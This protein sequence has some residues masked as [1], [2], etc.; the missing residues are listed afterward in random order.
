[1]EREVTDNCETILRQY[2][3][4]QPKAGDNAYVILARTKHG[5]IVMN[6][7]SAEFKKCSAKVRA[8]YAEGK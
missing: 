6:A 1:M 2:P 4:P 7:R 8:R 5:L 3:V